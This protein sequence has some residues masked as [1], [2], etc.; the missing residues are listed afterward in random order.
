MVELGAAC[1]L[2]CAA[3]KFYLAGKCEGCRKKRSE[4]CPIWKC[5]E[6]RGLMFCGE[7]DAFPCEKNYIVPALSKQWLDE[8]RDVFKKPQNANA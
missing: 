8:I 3:C 7:C 2:Y 1:G 6:D 5:A 4:K